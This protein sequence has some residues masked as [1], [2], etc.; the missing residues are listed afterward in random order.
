MPDIIFLPGAIGSAEFWRPVGSRLPTQWPKDFL[1][2]PGLGNQLHDSH[3]NSLEDLVQWVEA[4]VDRPVDL[5]AQSLGGFI[6]AR[7]ALAHPTKVRRLVLTVTSAGV[8]M[9]KFGASDWRADYR[10][11]FPNAADWLTQHQI[12][13]ELAV[14]RIQAPTLLIWGE[15]DTISPVAVGQHL[16]ARMPN[17]KL[18]VVPDGD[19]DLAHTHPELVAS[20]IAEHL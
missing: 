13:D 18:H 3:I 4:K 15:R 12:P 14:E 2:W 11:D 8:G 10:N 9:N 16:Q 17:A 6:A 19:H 5:V 1:N 20:L 7:V